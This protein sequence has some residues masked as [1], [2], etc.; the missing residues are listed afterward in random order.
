MIF[1]TLVGPIERRR[2][3]P[4]SCAPHRVCGTVSAMIGDTYVVLHSAWPA[5]L[6]AFF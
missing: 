4:I 1:F 6:L 3:L 2:S 5:W